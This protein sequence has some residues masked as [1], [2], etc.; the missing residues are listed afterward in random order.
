MSAEL[1]RRFLALALMLILS[2]HRAHGWRSFK[3]VFG[4]F[5]Y[6]A[7]AKLMDVKIELQNNSKSSLN[8][9]VNTL[10]ILDNVEVASRVSLETEPGNY[11]NLISRN[12]NFCKMLMERNVDPLAR[13]IYQDMQRYGKFFKE[14]PIQKGTYSLHDY[15]LD[16]ELLPSFL[17]ETNFKTSI[18]LFKPNSEQIFKGLFYGRIDKSKGFNNLKMFSMG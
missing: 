8:V 5:E 1:N 17:P 7:N 14:C 2:H 12:V 11:T 4:R 9:V 3:I 15:V 6:E 13:S 18:R 10:E 16:E